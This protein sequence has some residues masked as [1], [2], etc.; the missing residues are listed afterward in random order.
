MFF[1][2]GILYSIFRVHEK[3]TITS[4]QKRALTIVI[5]GAI[6]STLIGNYLY[7]VAVQKIGATTTS[8]ISASAPMVSTP[9]S[10][11][12]LSEKVSF[13]LIIATVL[14][15]TGIILIIS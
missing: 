10:A 6:L 9:L 7:L 11:I 14:T 4:F 15:I 12:F 5:I 13:W 1:G 2:A 3:N 8:A